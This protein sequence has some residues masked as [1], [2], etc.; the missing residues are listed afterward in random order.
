MSAAF[1][2]QGAPAGQWLMPAFDEGDG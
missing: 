1:V 2:L